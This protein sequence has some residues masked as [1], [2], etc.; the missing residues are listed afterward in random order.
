[1]ECLS[2]GSDE[3]SGLTTTIGGAG[4]ALSGCAYLLSLAGGA[5]TPEGGAPTFAVPLTEETGWEFPLLAM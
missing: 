1:M 5:M 2:V 4:V 3:V